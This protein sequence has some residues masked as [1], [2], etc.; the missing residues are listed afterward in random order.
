MKYNDFYNAK[1]GDIYI[2]NKWF[3]DLY[4]VGEQLIYID[5]GG[6]DPLTGYCTYMFNSVKTGK[7]HYITEDMLKY[8]ET[9]KTVRDNKITKL[10]S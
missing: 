3:S 8:I 10:L 4:R 7:K 6:I 1:A 2:I 5:F 9:I